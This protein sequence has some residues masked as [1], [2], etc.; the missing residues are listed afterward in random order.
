[1]GP[2]EIIRPFIRKIISEAFEAQELS[3]FLHKIDFD[4]TELNLI[5]YGGNGV[6][7]DIGNNKVLKITN[8]VEEAQT[9]AWLLEYDFAWIVKI[10]D[11]FKVESND[12]FPKISGLRFPYWADTYFIVEERL[13]TKGAS[14]EVAELLSVIINNFDIKHYRKLGILY[15]LKQQRIKN[16][17]QKENPE[18]I[19]I[20][21][22]VFDLLYSLEQYYG[23]KFLDFQSGNVGRDKNGK[24]KVFDVYFRGKKAEIRTIKI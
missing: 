4:F 6:A 22:E 1:M 5:A 21:N 3:E 16:Y 19:S 14:K 24:L 20:Y 15:Y 2:K 23:L 11:V 17:I 8:H 7:F 9:A 18:L 13:D 12:R 10:Y